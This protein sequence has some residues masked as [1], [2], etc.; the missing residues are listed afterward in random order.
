[1]QNQ[2]ALAVTLL[3]HIARRIQDG[4]SLS[5]IDAV[6]AQLAVGEVIDDSVD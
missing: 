6:D 3:N 5:G 2:G 4:A 1:M